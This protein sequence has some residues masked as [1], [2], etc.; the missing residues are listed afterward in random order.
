MRSALVTRQASGVTRFL[1]IFCFLSLGIC[2]SAYAKKAAKVTLLIIT[3]KSCKVCDTQKPVQY[4]KT[5]FPG[6]QVSYL[7]YPAETEALN[8]IKDLKLKTLPV[9]LLSREVEKEKTF[10]NFKGNVEIKGEFYML[11]PSFSGIAYFV[12]RKPEKGKLDVFISL[13]N[14]NIKALLGMLKEF[15]PDIHFLAVQQGDN[16]E[17]GTGNFEVEEYLRCVCVQKYYPD[18]FF[19]YVSCRANNMNSL[20]WDDCLAKTDTEK[21]KTCARSK[22]GVD[23]LRENIKL[24]RE[25][26]VMFGPTYLLNNQEIFGIQG[27]PPKEEFKK[28]I[29]R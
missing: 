10:A 9:Y 2:S 13:Y 24:N 16:F 5:Q 4:L 17:A 11:K 28:L 27:V 21:I 1:I 6:L 20:W 23:L 12:E 18:K 7:D 8:L 29:E 25:L 26:E 19:D 15:K 14:E 22:E 3:S